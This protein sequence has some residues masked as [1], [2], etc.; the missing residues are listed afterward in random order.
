MVYSGPADKE[1]HPLNHP[2]SNLSGPLK[3]ERGGGG[4]GGCTR[5]RVKSTINRREFEAYPRITQEVPL[6]LNFEGE[7]GGR[8]I[9]CDGISLW[10]NGYYFPRKMGMS[11]E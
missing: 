7:I 5:S 3:L 1:F 11:L 6:S 8:L 4:G 10:A 9:F 2:I